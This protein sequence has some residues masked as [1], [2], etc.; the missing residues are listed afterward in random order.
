MKTA[1]LFVAANGHLLHRLK[2]K[3]IVFLY[4]KYAQLWPIHIYNADAT[5]LSETV[6]LRR[7]HRC[8]LVIS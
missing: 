4:R 6:E 5:L 8:E 1:L 7:R 3:K 2:T